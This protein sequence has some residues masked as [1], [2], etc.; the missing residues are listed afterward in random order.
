MTL[1][2]GDVKPIAKWKYLKHL[3][4]ALHNLTEKYYADANITERDV[5]RV[6]TWFSKLKKYVEEG[7]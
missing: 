7:I 4:K 1:P 2:Q 6:N 5:Q 3:D